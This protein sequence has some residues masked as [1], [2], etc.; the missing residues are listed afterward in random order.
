MRF[1]LLFFTIL[2]IAVACSKDKD[3]LDEIDK[4]ANALRPFSVTVVERAPNTAIITWTEALNIY[5]SDTVKYDIVLNGK[6][7]RTDHFTLVRVE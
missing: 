6:T 4:K 1:S 5:N 2:I 3:P 7:V